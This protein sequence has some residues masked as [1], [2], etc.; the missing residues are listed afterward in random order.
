MKTFPLILLLTSCQL[1]RSELF[2]RENVLFQNI[3]TISTT[4]SRWMVT[5]VTDF[6]PFHVF[7]NN[8]FD[9]LTKAGSAVESLKIRF[10][11]ASVTLYKRVL[12]SIQT[13]IHNL[14][15]RRYQLLSV[16]NQYRSL[17]RKSKR[18]LIPIVG[19]ALSFLFGTV[20]EDDLNTIRRN[21]YNLASNQRK[22][23]HVIKDSLTLINNTRS[24]AQENRHA[25]NE[26]FESLSTLSIQF[27]NYSSFMERSFNDLLSFTTSY[28]KIDL[29][30][31]ELRQ[32]L[33]D[34][35][36]YIERLHIKF[37]MLSLGHLSPSL[38]SPSQ[39]QQLLLDIQ[40]KLP[41]YLQLTHDP[42]KEIWLFYKFL[43]CTTVIDLNKIY[44]I[45]SVPLIN[46]QKKFTIYKIHNIPF[47]YLNSSGQTTSKM[48]ALRDIPQRYIAV[49]PSRTHY[50]LL[51]TS[52]IQ[53]CTHQSL[54]FCTLNQ[55]IYPIRSSTLC[56]ISLFM[57]K[58]SDIQSFCNTIVKT[59]FDLPYAEY[60]TDGNFIIATRFPVTFTKVCKNTQSTILSLKPPIGLLK[61]ERECTAV[62]DSL[63]LP[64]YFYQE[65]K[66]LL[67]NPLYDILQNYNATTFN[68]WRPFHL[69]LPKLNV[70]YLPMLNDI[71]EI[72]MSHL[73]QKLDRMD[74]IPIEKPKKPIWPY[75]LLGISITL[76]LAI[77]V[78]IC[79]KLRKSKKNCPPFRSMHK[80]VTHINAISLIESNVSSP[81]ADTPLQE[82]DSSSENIP[83]QERDITL[84][85]VLELAKTP[86]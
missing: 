14:H 36:L 13:E 33:L 70:S 9:R 20:S 34:A 57:N 63:T 17:Q 86:S 51:T 19:K 11:K 73:I 60:I 68:L 21:I 5:F 30:L 49:N 39:L 8:L 41:P 53:T 6:Q 65:S 80:K 40:K 27:Q 31:L 77:S 85:P 50:I 66:F 15:R 79:L 38:I 58:P 35:S 2:I 61:L 26:I 29:F 56:V 71:P 25:I 52:D 55:P 3:D 81:L 74:D 16:F 32:Q 22:L 44:T 4:N 64:A 67:N 76:T 24:F 47:P 42:K 84:H 10:D 23:N 1:I 62:H 12:V 37:N 46:V 59:N 82:P 78:I 83:L 18:S 28:A 43:T 45:F 75:I 7:L 69:A 54:K 48:V 72:H